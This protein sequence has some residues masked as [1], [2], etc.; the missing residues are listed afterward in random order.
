MNITSAIPSNTAL[1]SNEPGKAEE[2]HMRSIP[3]AHRIRTSEKSQQCF[4]GTVAHTN[5]VFPE[6]RQLDNFVICAQANQASIVKF[7]IKTDFY[8]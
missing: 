4:S 1:Q 8:S 5:D 2:D 3:H 7:A 6:A